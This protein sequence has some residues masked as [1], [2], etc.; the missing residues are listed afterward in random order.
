MDAFSLKKDNRKKFQDKQ[1]LK[2]KHATPSDRKY[3]VLNRQKEEEAATEEQEQEQPALESNEVRYYEDPS[4]ALED[5]RTA[6]TSAEAN[7]VLRGVL[8][9]RLQQGDGNPGVDEAAN[10]DA[11]KIKDLKQMGVAELNRWLG[12]ENATTTATAAAPP[13]APHVESEQDPVSQKIL[14]RSADLPEDL[15]TDQDFLDGLL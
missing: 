6:A 13:A 14:S 8:R 11:L 1:K 7:R 5:P 9:N 2:R 15:E 12:R 4:L 10:T 3:R